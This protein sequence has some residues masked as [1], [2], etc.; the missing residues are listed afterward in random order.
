VEPMTYT[1]WRCARDDPRG[2]RGWWTA[3]YVHVVTD[4]VLDSLHA[5]GLRTPSRTPSQSFV[6]PW[7]GAVA[8]VG[9]D[10]TP[11]RQRDVTGW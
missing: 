6:V 1:D 8:R 9:E 10:D 3:E 11:L 7:G 2:Y 4:E 5:H